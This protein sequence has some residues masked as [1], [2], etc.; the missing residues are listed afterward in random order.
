ML[1]DTDDLAGPGDLAREH[2]VVNSCIAFW[3]RQPG[4]PE[5]VVHLSCGPIFSRFAVREWVVARR[6]LQLAKKL[7]ATKP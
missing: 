4:F 3:S 1:V 6:Q 2:G 5:P 7:A